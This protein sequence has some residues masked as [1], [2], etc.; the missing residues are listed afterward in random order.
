MQDL[1]D[2]Y[3]LIAG[4]KHKQVKEHSER[5]ANLAKKVANE[6]G[7]D[8]KAAYLA[9]IFHD[10]G[11][12]VL[13]FDLF[14]G[15]N[16]TSEEYEMVKEH[17]DYGFEILSNRMLFTALC[18]GFH[19]NISKSQG[20]GKTIEA[21][22]PNLS[23][24]TIKKILDI[25]TII[26]ICDFV[27]AYTTRTTTAKDGASSKPLEEMLHERFPEESKIIEILLKG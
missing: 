15:H 17:V 11:K 7:K 19:H 4:V 20:Y 14:D 6:L 12:I 1:I 5:V 10:I 9:G 23:L 3:F 18:V 22:P 27:D 26:S 25:S 21:F 24:I 8:E 16:I 2:F 13:P